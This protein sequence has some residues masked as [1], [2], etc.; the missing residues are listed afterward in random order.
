MAPFYRRERRGSAQHWVSG[1]CRTVKAFSRACACHHYCFL[2][3]V[4]DSLLGSIVRG[5]YQ[6]HTSDDTVAFKP[7]SRRLKEAPP[8]SA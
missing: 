2:E 8:S 6:L 3:V 5:V 1:G 4:S 7:A